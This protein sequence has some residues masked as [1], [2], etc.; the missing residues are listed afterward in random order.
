MRHGQV[1]SSIV[2]VV[3][4]L[5]GM[6]ARIVCSSPGPTSVWRIGFRIVVT[7]ASRTD[8]GVPSAQL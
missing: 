5:V 7:Q 2:F 8:G 3:T 4:P 6:P 1:A